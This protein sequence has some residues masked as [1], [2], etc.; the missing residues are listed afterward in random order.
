MNRSAM[1]DRNIFRDMLFSQKMM[2]ESYNTFANETL[3]PALRDEFLNLLNDEH[4]MEGEIFD[5]I[6]ARGWY[7]TVPADPQKAD[8]ILK[9]YQK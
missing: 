7:P 8:Q 5:E 9:K 1:E 3:T 6:R 2:T 4:K